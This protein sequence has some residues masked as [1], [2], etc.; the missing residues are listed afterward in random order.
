MKSRRWVVN[1]EEGLT[2]VD[3]H[4]GSWF[5]TVLGV[6]QLTCRGRK[7]NEKLQISLD[8][9]AQYYYVKLLFYSHVYTYVYPGCYDIAYILYSE[10]LSNF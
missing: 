7:E 8:G 1:S 2:F 9:R 4:G 3:K 6:S 5:I 10:L